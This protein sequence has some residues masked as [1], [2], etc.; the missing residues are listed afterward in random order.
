MGV[1]AI[2]KTLK[3]I[4]YIGN[5]SFSANGGDNDNGVQVTNTNNNDDALSK[6]AQFL[7]LDTIS[8]NRALCTKRISIRN[9]TTYVRLNES[10]AV[11][12]RDSL[13]R[14][15]YHNIFCYIVDFANFTLRLPSANSPVHTPNK[16]G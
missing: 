2:E 1:E 4:L 3:A 15:M 13:A 9:S 5:I 6:V 10:Q 11:Q 16:P 7:G 12:Q 8:L 14:F